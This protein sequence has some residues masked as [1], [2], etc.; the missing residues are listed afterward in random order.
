MEKIN[1]LCPFCLKVNK[2]PQKD[3]YKKALCGICKESLLAKNLINADSTTF[4]HILVNSEIPVI[5]DFWAAW[6]APC[7]AFSPIF[8]QVSASFTLKALFIKVNTQENEALARKYSIVSL[9]TLLVFK[10][11][12]EVKRV[13]GLL[14]PSKLS[15]LV[16]DLL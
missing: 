9:P 7:K 13:S 11:S 1:I 15:I 8:K 3:T 6:C 12:K 16:Q 14:D 10:N 2:I 4:D 5:I